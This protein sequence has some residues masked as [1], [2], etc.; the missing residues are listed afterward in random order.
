MH[1][2]ALPFELC[3]IFPYILIQLE[4]DCPV[5]YIKG[6][7]VTFLNYNV[8]LSLQVVLILAN[9]ED[10]DEMPRFAAFHLGLT[11]CQS[12]RLGVSSIQRVN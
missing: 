9:S 10:L 8:F 11:V 4:W 7:Q 2:Q 1:E 6:S 12:T 3:W 5:L